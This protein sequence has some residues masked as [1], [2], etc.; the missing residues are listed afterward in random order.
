[1]KKTMFFG[2][3]IAIAIFFTACNSKSGKLQPSVS[4][5][6]I[7]FQ[8]FYVA[9]YDTIFTGEVISWEY[10][11]R[12]DEVKVIFDGNSDGKGV[13]VF[14][15]QKQMRDVDL[16]LVHSLDSIGVKKT[17]KLDN[18]GDSSVRFVIQ[19]YYWDKPKYTDG[20]KIFINPDMMSISFDENGKINYADITSFT[21]DIKTVEIGGATSTVIKGILDSEIGRPLIEAEYKDG[22]FRLVSY[23]VNQ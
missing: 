7:E 8:N 14:G 18:A 4:T 22:S 9:G 5:S 15:N 23:S 21:G 2:L 3:I 10:N 16:L 11:S 13:F 6:D 1:M 19:D 17:W 12:K 20:D